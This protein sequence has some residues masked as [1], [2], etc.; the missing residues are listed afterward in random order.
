MHGNKGECHCYGQGHD[1]SGGTTEI[2]KENDHHQ[3][4]DDRFLD[5][6]PFEGRDRLTDQVGPVVCGDDL[7][8]F[9]QGAFRLGEFGFDAVY[10]LQNILA[11]AHH[12][13]SPH[14]LPLAIQIPGPTPH[15]RTQHNIPGHIPQQNRSPLCIRPHHNLLQILGRLNVALAADHVGG[16]KPFQLTPAH[17][18]I[19]APDGGD[20]RAD[21]DVIHQQLV[22]IEFHLV[23]FFEPAKCGHLGHPLDALQPVAQVPILKG[24][25]LRRIILSAAIPEGVLKAPSHAACIRSQSGGDSGRQRASKALEIFKHAGSCPVNIGTI[26]K[27]RINKGIPEERVAPDHP[28]TRG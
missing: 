28:D 21:R 2:Q 16:A 11:I 23:L 12:H 15:F 20:D 6:R 25:Q 22:R 10:D 27:H 3:R 1:R 14:S 19:G 24:S 18:V 26:G 7:N 13:D 4:H 8:P 9:R 5:D 17:V